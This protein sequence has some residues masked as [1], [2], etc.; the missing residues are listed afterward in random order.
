MQVKEHDVRNILYH[1]GMLFPSTAAIVAL[2]AYCSSYPGCR[3]SVD[4]TDFRGKYA[5]VRGLPRKICGRPRKKRR[6]WKIL[7]DVRGHA[8]GRPRTSMDIARTSAEI[9]DFEKMRHGNSA[10]GRT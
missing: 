7:T 8:H 10:D 6:A 1:I 9:V 2:N 3:I 5:D 4:S